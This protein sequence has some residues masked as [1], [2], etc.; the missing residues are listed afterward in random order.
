M[1][2]RPF[3]EL[4]DPIKANPHRA[5]RIARERAKALAELDEPI[6]EPKP[7]ADQPDR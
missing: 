5:A 1:P 7:E 2:T 6:P 3:K 4:A